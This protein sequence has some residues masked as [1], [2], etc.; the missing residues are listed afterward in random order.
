[1]RVSIVV[2]NVND[3][4]VLAQPADQSVSEGQTLTLQLQ[5]GDVDAGDVLGYALEQAPA[6]ASITPQGLVRWTAGNRPSRHDFVVRVTD[7]AGASVQRG[8]A[9][10]VTNAP[11][12]RSVVGP[13]VWS[14]GQPYT[15]NLQCSD[16][17]GD[18][19]Q[20]WRIE[21]GDGAVSLLPGSATRRPTPTAC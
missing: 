10:D 9:V 15:L 7:A 8:F 4:P 11:P 14:A 5:A 16:A 13:A 19:P 6:G 12:Q 1:M 21:W 3:A 18:T 17:G 2:R 20:S